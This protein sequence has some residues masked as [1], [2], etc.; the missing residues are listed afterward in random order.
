MPYM[1]LHMFWSCCAT[2]C[3]RSVTH[4]STW[5]HPVL[6]PLNSGVMKKAVSAALEQGLWG[7]LGMSPVG[8]S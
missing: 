7:R 8:L 6:L 4:Q 2:R 3:A 1:R 5:L